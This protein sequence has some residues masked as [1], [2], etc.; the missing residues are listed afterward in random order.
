MKIHLARA[1]AYLASAFVINSCAH[2]TTTSPKAEDAPSIIATSAHIERTDFRA[3]GRR[4][5]ISTQ[6]RA[7]TP[8]AERILKSG[9]NVIDA[10]LAA[11][12][13]ISVERPHSTGLAG[14]GFFLYFDAKTG[15]TYAVDFRE[16][17]PLKSK[18]E[19]FL[20]AKGEP[21]ATRSQNGVLAVAVPGLVAGL[22]EIHKRFGSKPLKEILT[23][24]IELAENGFPIYPSLDK[25]IR[26]KAALLRADPAA[27]AI[28]LDSNGDPWPQG[29]L[30]VQKD[31]AKTLRL[32]AKKGR[33]G[34]YKGSVA[35]AITSYMKKNGG[36]IEARDL[37]SFQVKWREPVRGSFRGYEIAS[38]PPPSS[39]GVHVIQ[40]LNMLENDNL[41]PMGPSSA[42]AMHLEASALQMAF[43][44]RAR[45]LGDPD[46]IKV[47]V[48]SLISKPYAQK[49]RSEIISGKARALKAVSPGDVAPYESTET[50]HFSIIDRDGNAVASTQ[51]IN[52]YMGA[53]LVVPGTGLVLNNEM[54]DFSAK[55]GAANLFGAIGSEANLVAPKKTP[56][57]SMSPTLLMKDGRVE[58]AVGAP[59]GTRIISCVA[60]TILNWTEFKMPLDQAISTIRLHHQWSPDVLTIDPPGPSP[61][62]LSQLKEFG[63]R[64]EIEPVPC[65]VMAVAREGDVLKAASDPRDIGTS[66]AE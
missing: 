33:D 10:A 30:L 26:Q 13:A 34:F 32:I 51:T 56:L 5:A 12:F 48:K 14:G 31:L 28:F 1:I 27:R 52:G 57:S 41:K 20:D 17:A 55:P 9:G 25:A 62:T 63:Y 46:F 47:P 7:A 54:D 50:T 18:P 64:V 40:F 45:Y 53:S 8:A 36:L 38:M 44:D 39:G 43:A 60:E 4:F 11:S 2:Q 15:R 3:E 66:S 49:R 22:L 35:G 24:A 21:V 58:L 37:A 29:H 16:R 59:G 19:M 6:G 65:N 61:A 42:E 23:P